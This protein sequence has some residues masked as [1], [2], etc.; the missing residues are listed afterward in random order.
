MSEPEPQKNSPEKN[1]FV[2]KPPEPQPS[3]LQ[4][5]KADGKKEREV[6]FLSQPASE[7]GI[8]LSEFGLLK[9]GPF[10]P[11]KIFLPPQKPV[12]ERRKLER[13]ESS[14]APE[15]KSLKTAY[16]E[17]LEIIYQQLIA[18]QNYISVNGG[19]LSSEQQAFLSLYKRLGEGAAEKILATSRG[20][21]LA[22]SLIEQE[23][24]LRLAAL[25]KELSFSCQNLDEKGLPEEVRFKELEDLISKFFNNLKGT[26]HV[27]KLLPLGGAF[28]TGGGIFGG[29]LGT[30]LTTGLTIGGV[31]GAS[32]AL[33]LIK[34]GLQS[35]FS[36]LKVNLE[37]LPE[38]TKGYLEFLNSQA[39]QKDLLEFI[40]NSAIA[41]TVFL[42][43]LGWDSNSGLVFAWE[44]FKLSKPELPETTSQPF[45]PATSRVR[46]GYLR[47]LL[48]EKEGKELHQDV[49]LLKEIENKLR[50]AEKE[51][52]KKKADL[53]ISLKLLWLAPKSLLQDLQ[54][55]QERTEVLNQQTEAL[56]EKI[57]SRKAR[58]F[59]EAQRRTT[60][61]FLNQELEAILE[62][63]PE[64]VPSSLSQI[65]AKM[66][67]LVTEEEKEKEEEERL[68]QEKEKSLAEKRK[69][70]Q[71]KLA[72]FLKNDPRVLKGK[73]EIERYSNF[74]DLQALKETI[75][76]EINETESKKKELLAKVRERAE[77]AELLEIN[78]RLLALKDL[79]KLLEEDAPQLKSLE[80]EK[81]RLEEEIRV[82][83]TKMISKKERE[84]KL[85]Q[86]RA[87]AACLEQAGK[88]LGERVPAL[89]ISEENWRRLTNI[90]QET[91]EGFD[92]GRIKGYLEFLKLLFDYEHPPQPV[93][94]SQ[95]RPKTPAEFFEAAKTLISEGELAAIL[96]EVL[97]L[98]VTRES[99]MS[100]E[101]FLAETLKR[102]AMKL[103]SLPAP[104]VLGRVMLRLISEIEH[105][106][107]RL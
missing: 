26:P 92:K 98:A 2:A 20:W 59:F 9:A 25:G 44:G 43:A 51:M 62:S 74:T 18:Y 63:A 52:A 16:A 66:R 23:I 4:P 91:R 61:F 55:T 94:E 5:P 29:P 83:T 72:A 54:E 65:E 87:A 82:L 32:E 68:V 58:I 31:K 10:E 64:A 107:V 77:N 60:A 27:D 88:T 17:Q 3:S 30:A 90:I 35:G 15:Q 45:L 102:T 81:E 6:G 48:E 33:R 7:K 50:E 13:S 34:E 76:Q 39:N 46:T 57:L 47:Q 85:S 69:N 78:N 104:V 75:N 105:K 38:S 22:Q 106:A 96:N 84:T 80:E 8:N 37:N 97:N 24:F 1:P 19:Q 12:E 100:D 56:R 53:R 71:E 73:I 79:L 11:E 42:E 14:K 103:G 28:V 49:A 101:Q 93:Q 67:E 41:Q 21:L 70:F 99:E 40:K 36:D 86:L 89:A 95:F